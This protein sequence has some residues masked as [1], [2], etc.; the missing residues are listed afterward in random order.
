MVVDDNK[1]NCGY[2]TPQ[3]VQRWLPWLMRTKR[4]DEDSETR[5]G[6]VMFDEE[7]DVGHNLEAGNV[8]IDFPF[9]PNVSIQG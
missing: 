1:L 8:D 3:Q 5:G 9:P 7:E 6:G 2:E 4:G